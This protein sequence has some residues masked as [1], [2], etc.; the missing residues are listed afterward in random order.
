MILSEDVT[1]QP[2][3]TKLVHFAPPKLYEQ[4]EYELRADAWKGLALSESRK[5]YAL[6][7]GGPRIYIESDKSLYKPEDMVQFRVIILNEHVKITKIVEP[8][9]I[10]ILVSSRNIFYIY[11]TVQNMDM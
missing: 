6:E 9:R 7:M 3:E 10:Q 8:I 2:F 11:Y 4:F 5:L 1:L